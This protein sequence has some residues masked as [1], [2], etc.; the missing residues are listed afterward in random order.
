MIDLPDQPENSLDVQVGRMRSQ[1]ASIER[2]RGGQA[3]ST[4]FDQSTEN[5]RTAI[6]ELYVAEEELRLQHEELLSARAELEDQ[7]RRYEELFQLAPDAY[8]VTNPLGIVREVNRA[9]ADLVGVEP[10]FLLGKPL[11]T[12]V[13]G[14]DRPDLRAL[15]NEFGSATHV[16]DWS[17]HLMPRDGVP[18]AVSVSASAARGAATSWWASAGS[19]AT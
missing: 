12:F 14:D 5:L 1:L 6:E 7:R 15:I 17:L 16:A 9:A 10:R 4:G 11:M 2:E 19:S 18:I 8:L 13:D 3:G